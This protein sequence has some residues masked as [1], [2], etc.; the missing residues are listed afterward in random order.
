MICGNKKR[1]FGLS[2]GNVIELYQTKKE[3]I[4]YSISKFKSEVTCLRF[5]EDGKIV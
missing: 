1:N 3:A 2:Y 4:Q 5:R